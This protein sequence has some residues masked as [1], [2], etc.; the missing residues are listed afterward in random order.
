MVRTQKFLFFS[1]FIKTHAQDHT[2]YAQKIT[3]NQLLK[4]EGESVIHY[5]Y[6]ASPK[7][8]QMVII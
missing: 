4:G 6:C 8:A 3:F 7:Y 1:S 2:V 5:V